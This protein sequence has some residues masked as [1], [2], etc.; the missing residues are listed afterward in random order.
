MLKPVALW[1][2]FVWL[3]LAFGCSSRGDCQLLVSQ[4]GEDDW[5]L[6]NRNL[7]LRQRADWLDGDRH[8]RFLLQ[9]PSTMPGL[10]KLFEPLPVVIQDETRQILVMW[11]PLNRYRLALSRWSMYVCAKSSSVTYLSYP[12]SVVLWVVLRLVQT[13]K[14]A[15]SSNGFCALTKTY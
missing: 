4:N 12:I 15:D 10:G 1:C 2:Y 13:G 8:E 3:T 9:N 14:L 11:S 5:S 6:A 7:R